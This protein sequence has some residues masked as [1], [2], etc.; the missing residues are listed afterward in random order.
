MARSGR[1]RKECK[2]QLYQDQSADNELMTYVVY[3]NKTRQFGQ[4]VRNGLRLIWSLGQGDL[5]VL[6]ELFPALQNQ[7]MP[8]PEDLVEQ[9]RQLLQVRV[10]APP[11]PEQPAGPQQLELPMLD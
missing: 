10:A 4:V 5:S 6:F 7:F 8:R 3:L 1:P 9:F 2:F 11:P